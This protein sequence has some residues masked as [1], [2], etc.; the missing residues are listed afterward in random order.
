L[1]TRGAKIFISVLPVSSDFV[2]L[3][4]LKENFEGTKNIHVKVIIL[5]LIPKD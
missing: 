5:T 1:W 3:Q 2:I 4:K